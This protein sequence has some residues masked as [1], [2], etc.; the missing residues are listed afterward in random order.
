[1]GLQSIVAS[2][3]TKFSEQTQSDMVEPYMVTASDGGKEPAPR[4]LGTQEELLNVF[5]RKKRW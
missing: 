1:M 3:K 5:L 2:E 4:E